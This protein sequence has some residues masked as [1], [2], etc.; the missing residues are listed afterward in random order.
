MG[1]PADGYVG[2]A[3]E[4]MNLKAAG[5]MPADPKS[6]VVRAD[7]TV[8]AG[9]KADSGVRQTAGFATLDGG[10]RTP[11]LHGGMGGCADG[12][13]GVGGPSPYG[14]M[15]SG[16]GNYLGHG[17][18]LPV[19]G[20]GPPGAVAA[21]GAMGG[22]HGMYAPL[23]ANQRTSVRFASPAG[24]SISWQGPG[25]Q[26]IDPAPLQTPVRYNFA[27]GNIYRLRL[28]NIPNRPG[29][30]PFY[31]TLEVY[32]ATPTTVTFLSHST[33]PVSFSDDDFEQVNAGN[34]VVKVIY[35]PFPQFQDLAALGGG[36]LGEVISTRLEPGVNPIEEA[37]R[38][39]TILAVVRMGNIDLQDPN[40][41]AMDAP[42]GMMPGGPPKVIGP[43]P[44]GGMGAA[45]SVTPNLVGDPGTKAPIMPKVASTPPAPLPTAVKAP[46]SMPAA[47]VKK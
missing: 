13:C 36:E 3:G 38:R 2:P 21:V 11:G 24:M 22:G 26:F 29:A 47:P 31:P 9:K 45:P 34:L 20:M 17:G 35:L 43:L 7:M 5:Q 15:G 46:S 33:V 12:N 8:P 1:Q 23:Y 32:P 40:T 10:V 27:Q 18:I 6:K 41:P 14:P 25:G 42:S 19:P 37:H 28:S 30:R 44:P 39:G 4:P 16:F